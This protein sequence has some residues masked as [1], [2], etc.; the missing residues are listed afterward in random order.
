MAGASALL[1]DRRTGEIVQSQITTAAGYAC[2]N[3]LLVDP[4]YDEFRIFIDES[5]Y[6]MR[7]DENE[8]ETQI[9]FPHFM[10]RT[11]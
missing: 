7:W 5:P 1:Q 4:D 8:G 10:E 3:V 6:N 2:F 11:R 9:L